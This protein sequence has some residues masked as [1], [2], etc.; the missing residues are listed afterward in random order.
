MEPVGAVA[1]GVYCGEAGELR[2]VVAVAVVVEG[3]GRVELFAEVAEVGGVS[4]VS[5]NQGTEG[6]VGV[7]GF[8]GTGAGGD[9]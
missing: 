1:D 9:G 6:V 7:G 8:L 3:G 5:S 2:V 4:E